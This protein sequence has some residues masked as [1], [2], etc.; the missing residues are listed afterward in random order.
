[1]E[2]NKINSTSEA[3]SSY[4]LLDEGWGVSSPSAPPPPPPP[5]PP[6]PT[7]FLYER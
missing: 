4:P 3:P 6:L 7:S 2:G 1:M 5:A